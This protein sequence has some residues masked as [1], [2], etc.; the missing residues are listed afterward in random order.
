MVNNPELI[1]QAINN[2]KKLS[3][4]DLDK[5]MKE[6]DDWYNKEI[7]NINT[8]NISE[9]QSLK[10]KIIELLKQYEKE[11]ND[12]DIKIA[13]IIKLGLNL[14]NELQK[15]NEEKDKQIKNDKELK[16]RL[17]KE[18]NQVFSEN[19]KLN[20]KIVIL[21]EKINNIT[22]RLNNKIEKL[23]Q[24]ISKMHPASDCVIIE[25]L[26]IK[27]QVLEELLKESKGEY[28]NE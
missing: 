3:K 9:N 8:D 14:I 21:E 24:R 13:F 17:C 12:K 19:E 10:Q 22:Q 1:E 18:I 25:E 28:K 15:E 2:I 5:I 26:E 20:E 27:L 4:E 11:I 23:K 16:K 7:I 6:A